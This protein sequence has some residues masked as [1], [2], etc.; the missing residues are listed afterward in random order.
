MRRNAEARSFT[1]GV[2]AFLPAAT[3]PLIFHNREA[4]GM[5]DARNTLT[6][7]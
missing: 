5:A 3:V 4:D 6:F 1:L 7:C 2:V